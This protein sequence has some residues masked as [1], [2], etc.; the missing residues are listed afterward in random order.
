MCCGCI[1]R[2]D[3]DDKVF[4]EVGLTVSRRSCMASASF[5][6]LES[7]TSCI[8]SRRLACCASW[9]FAWVSCSLD[10]LLWSKLFWAC[11]I[12]CC[13]VSLAFRR[14]WSK[15]VVSSGCCSCLSYLIFFFILRYKHCCPFMHVFILTWSAADFSAVAGSS[16]PNCK[17]KKERNQIVST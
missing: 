1:W 7:W 15:D 5:C 17:K 12:R 6:S 10:R 3:K 8:A 11:C 13:R 9:L 2:C 14:R 4:D 16:S